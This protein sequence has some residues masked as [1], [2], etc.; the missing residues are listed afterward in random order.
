MLT[1]KEHRIKGSGELNEMFN[2]LSRTAT[3][4]QRDFGEIESLQS[5]IKGAADFVAKAIERVEAMILSD[6]QLI[7]P[8]AGITTTNEF[9]E[10]D[11][12]DE[13]V[14]GFSGAGN[15]V[16]GNPH[17]AISLALKHEGETAIGLIYSPIDDRLYF[18]EKGNGAFI[19]APFHSQRMR[20]ST[21]T[22]PTDLTIYKSFPGLTGESRP[23]ISQIPT[24]NLR[25]S[26]CPALDLA[27]VASGKADIAILAN[28]GI[29]EICAGQLLVEEANGFVDFT[30]GDI[31]AASLSIKS[32]I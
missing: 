7:R 12:V 18:A 17:F 22:E 4:I 28:D 19:F 25:I 21:R 20:A 3:G 10:G 2:A 16:R 11:G 5:S 32:F 23:L 24:S 13:F 15:F 14:L 26:G 1:E 6:L 8:Q 30:N 31:L 29:S 9:R 27:Y